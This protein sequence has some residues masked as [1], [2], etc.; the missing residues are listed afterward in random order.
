MEK[1][2]LSCWI[3][4][5]DLFIIYF[6]AHV[7]VAGNSSDRAGFQTGWP[8]PAQGILGSFAWAGA[9]PGCCFFGERCA[10]ACP[11]CRATS[12][13]PGSWGDAGG[14]CALRR[15]AEPRAFGGGGPEKPRLGGISL[16]T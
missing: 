10:G 9:A 1:C 3:H 12:S 5:C 16:G 13:C 14:G 7:S 15:R 4:K 11:Q 6:F 2:L 8:S